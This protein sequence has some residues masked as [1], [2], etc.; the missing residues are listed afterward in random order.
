MQLK[1]NNNNYKYRTIFFDPIIHQQAT[2]TNTEQSYS[3]RFI[4]QKRH[5]YYVIKTKDIAYFTFKDNILHIVTFNKTRYVMDKNVSEIERTLNTSDF[6]RINRQTI[7]NIEAFDYYENHFN[8]K[9]LLHFKDNILDPILAGR[10][11]S[12]LFKKWLQGEF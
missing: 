3:T 5:K 11:K 12:A 6:F 2:I 10:V 8:Y 7:I 4:V 9:I 1:D